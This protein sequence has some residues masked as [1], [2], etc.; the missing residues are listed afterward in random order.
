MHSP[1]ALTALTDTLTLLAEVRTAPLDRAAARLTLS[2]PPVLWIDPDST[3]ETRC[4]ALLDAL[5]VL[6]L[7]PEHAEHAQRVRPLRAV[8]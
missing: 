8:K 2:T 3:P 4:R 5:R 7:G 1:T 6:L